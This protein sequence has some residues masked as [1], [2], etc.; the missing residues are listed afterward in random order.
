MKM[1]RGD[2]RLL[3]ALGSVG[4]LIALLL[5]IVPGSMPVALGQTAGPISTP[6]G[7]QRCVN[8]QV[9]PANLQCQAPTPSF[10]VAS[11][12]TAPLQPLAPQ[13]VITTGPTATIVAP[14]AVVAPTTVVPAGSPPAGTVSPQPIVVTTP[15]PATSTPPTSTTAPAVTAVPTN[16][17]TPVPTTVV[18]NVNLSVSSGDNIPRL[19]GRDNTPPIGVDVNTNYS[20]GGASSTI[21]LSNNTVDGQNLTQTATIA[22]APGVQATSVTVST[23]S[24][25]V[26]GNQIV[27]TNFSLDSG[28]QATATVSV[29]AS[30]GGAL[31]ASGAP[32]VASVQIAAVDERTGEAVTEQAS[33]TALLAAGGV[34]AG[35]YLCQAAA[36]SFSCQGGAVR[37]AGAGPAVVAAAPPVAAPVSPSA[38][39][40]AI[41][42]LPHT[43]GKG[44]GAELLVVL[45]GGLILLGAGVWLTRW[46]RAYESN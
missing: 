45:A 27:W 46:R 16:P 2:P 10:V 42:L 22:L 35:E 39:I 34:G 32:V 24:A 1:A 4:I 6:A 15:A 13:P 17:P 3:V 20:S 28:Q 43:G 33:A 5:A 44:P 12:T 11:P 23:G 19:P 29:V 36:G 8:G 30:G 26:Q 38:P 21:T 37:T 18:N 31:V 9:I 41:A 25:V 40:G 7:T 14:T